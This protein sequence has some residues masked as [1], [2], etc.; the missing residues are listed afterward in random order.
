MPRYYPVFL[1]LRDRLCLVLG[2]G[3]LAEEKLPELLAAGA[4][5][6][7]V[8]AHPSPGIE[9]LARAGRLLL[10]RRAYRD[11]DLAGAFLAIAAPD[12]GEAGRQGQGGASPAA[13]DAREPG[14][15]GEPG[16]ASDPGEAGK[17]SEPADARDARDARAAGDAGDAGASLG[18]Q[19]AIWRE[20]ERRGLPLNSI[21]DPGRSSF[22]AGAV[23]RR[24]DLTVAV[25]TAGKAPALAVRLRQ[26]LEGAL[27]AHHGRFLELAGAVRAT[28]AAQQPDLARRRERW[29]RL[30]DSDV[31]DLLHRGDE[32]AAR[33][34][35][36]EILGVEPGAALFN[37]ASGGV[38]AGGEG[39]ATGEEAR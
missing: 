31:L 3:A 10:Q 13:G 7:V 15:P 1:D 23:V 38:L 2:G 5:V 25:S 24:G 30:V 28:L 34:R 14:E 18:R 4:R 27:G 16:D 17:A 32:P 9:T 37:V 6:V 39:A 22:I 21:D 11:G 29:Y 19:E 35:F 36:A 26:W 33:R 20:A 12:A 8:A